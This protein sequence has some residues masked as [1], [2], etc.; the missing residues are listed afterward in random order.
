MLG[1]IKSFNPSFYPKI[2]RQ[3]L[4][5][6]LGFFLV[7]IIIISAILSFKI[8][9][10]VK[11]QLPVAE[12]WLY[13]NIPQIV[14]D[15]PPLEIENGNL[16]LPEK[17]YI[18][19]WED[20]FSL[21]IE[22]DPKKIYPILDEYSNVVVFT[23]KKLIIKTSNPK[24]NQSK[25]E[26]QDL[27]KV[28]LFKIDQIDTGL[29]FTFE[30]KEFDVTP[31]TIERFLEKL[32]LFVFPLVFL[33]FFCVYI[34][35]KPAQILIFSLVSLIFNKNLKTGL[36]Y[37]QLLNIGT[38]ALVP[39]TLLAATK[40]I[41]NLKIPLFGAVYVLIY[42]LYFFWGIKATRELPKEIKEDKNDN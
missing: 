35:T 8:S 42:I 31:S 15:F 1:I 12:A 29:K 5:K 26:T 11:R 30:N 2:T 10:D 7:F 27:S 40:D 20:Q 37:K 25:V 18:K 21:V 34:F 28:K 4:W 39:P 41:A 14:S 32:Y 16:V 3:S 24:T 17:T 9:S 33:W 6:S 38:Y 13:E 19:E 36:S 22:P 23:Q